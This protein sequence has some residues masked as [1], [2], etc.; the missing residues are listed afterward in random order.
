MEV[1]GGRW[2]N[3]RT[4][5]VEEEETGG[6]EDAGDGGSHEVESHAVEEDVREALVGEAGC[7]CRPPTSYH[8]ILA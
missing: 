5:E 3:R 2:G 1:G 4:A 8:V 7:Q 6:T